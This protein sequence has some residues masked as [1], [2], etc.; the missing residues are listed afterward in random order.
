MA[1]FDNEVLYCRGERLEQ[2]NAQD[3]LL[4]QE[5][6]TDVARINHTGNPEGA[7]AANPSSLSHDPVSGNLY[8]KAT[9]TGNTGWQ[10]V[11]GN[12]I[13]AFQGPVVDFT[14]LGTTAIFTPVRDFQICFINFYGVSIVG[15][16]SGFQANF[17]TNPPDFDNI[18]AAAGSNVTATGQNQLVPLTSSGFATIPAGETFTCNVVTAESGA[19][20]S[21]QRIDV[22]GYYIN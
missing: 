17:G 5:Q 12:G 20:T 16:I 3:I 19:T 9:G 11:F 8:L 10:Q 6:A 13:I 15:S 7:V 18:L 21:D 4:M 2:S 22:I 14:T 1:G